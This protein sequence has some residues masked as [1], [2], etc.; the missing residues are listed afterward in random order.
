MKKF[1][2]DVIES[3]T[4]RFEVE[5][6]DADDAEDLGKQGYG[7]LISKNLSRLDAT[8]QEIIRED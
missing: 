2:V 6:E 4:S 5:A 7:E 3:T 8:A 1:L